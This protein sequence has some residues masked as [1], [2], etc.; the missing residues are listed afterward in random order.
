MTKPD[1]YQRQMIDVLTPELKDII[2]QDKAL[3]SFDLFGCTRSDDFTGMGEI[4]SAPMTR[5][6]VF[7]SSEEKGTYNH[8]M[9]LTKWKDRYWLAW[10]NGLKHEECP[11]QR[12]LIS[13]SEDGRTWSE[14]ILVAD[15]N[16][17]EGIVSNLGGI[18]VYGDKLYAF[19]QEKRDLARAVRPDLSQHDNAKVKTRYD[20]FETS[21]GLNWTQHKDRLPDVMWTLENPRLTNENRLLAPATTRDFKPAI[22][23]WPGADPREEPQVIPIPYEGDAFEYFKGHDEGLYVYGESSWYEDEDGRM[24]LWHRDDSAFGYLGVALSEDG[25]QTWTQVIRSNFPDA[26]S[27]I[28]AGR[29][30][31]GRF[32][33]LGNSIAQHMNRN[34][35][36]IALSDDGAKFN[37]MYC[38]IDK[39]TQQR[40]QGHLKVHGYQYPSACV[41]GNRLVIAYSVNKEDIEVGILRT[42]QI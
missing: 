13:H 25:G 10:D 2:S 34:F 3:R 42:D 24:W 27:R 38:L 35:F 28:F 6:S 40:F 1:I 8:H 12:T 18:C 31:D 22:I 33:I 20:L 32:Y 5:H 9:C 30:E 15:G 16:A 17:S 4:E 29:L 37:K 14:P 21:D 41:D 11:G 36:S 23:L 19:V 7:E 26:T 39:P